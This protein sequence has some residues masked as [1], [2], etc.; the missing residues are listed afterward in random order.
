MPPG[1][2]SAEL[3]FYPRR[4]F[5]A[6]F[7]ELSHIWNVLRPEMLQNPDL[8][9]TLPPEP[10]RPSAQVPPLVS[11][12]KVMI[13]PSGHQSLNER[14]FAKLLRQANRS[15]ALLKSEIPYRSLA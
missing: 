14:S 8:N 11:I 1:E 10:S 2:L 4:D 5:L 9:A 6:P 13:G 7:V 15:V 12:T 3:C